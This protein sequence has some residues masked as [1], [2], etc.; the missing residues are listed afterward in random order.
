MIVVSILVLQIGVAPALAQPDFN[1]DIPKPPDPVT[2]VQS[3]PV[4]E[5]FYQD[6]ANRE[7]VRKFMA[8]DEAYRNNTLPPSESNYDPHRLANQ[9]VEIIQKGQIQATYSLNDYRL[10]PIEVGHSSLRI[11]YSVETRELLFEGVVGAKSDGTLGD[12][13]ARH[14]IP[15]IDL[16]SY[17][18]DLEMLTFID[19][20]GKLHA[21]DMGFAV[22]QL[23]KSPIPI[24]TN[25]WSPDVEFF[26]KYKPT[27]YRLQYHVRAITPYSPEQ[28]TEFSVIPQNSRGQPLF[29]AGDVYIT[30][31]DSS[32]QERVLG[33]FS[34]EIIHERFKHSATVLLA[35]ASL[36]KPKKEFLEFLALKL[37]GAEPAPELLEMNPLLRN[38]LSNLDLSQLQTLKHRAEANETAQQRSYDQYTLDE[39]AQDAQRLNEEF[40]KAKAAASDKATQHEVALRDIYQNFIEQEPRQNPFPPKETVMSKMLKRTDTESFRRIAA[41][42]AAGIG[43]SYL[44]FPFLYDLGL[45]GMEI[46]AMNWIYE[47]MYTDVMKGMYK[48]T[49]VKSIFSLLLMAPFIIYSCVFIQSMLKVLNKHVEHKDTWWAHKIKDVFKNWNGLTKWEFMGSIGLRQVFLLSYPPI[50]ALFKYIFQQRAFLT[51]VENGINPFKLVKPESPL[52]KLLEIQ[53]P[54]RMGLMSFT[55]PQGGSPSAREAL[56]KMNETIK[57]KHDR[58]IEIQS[59]VLNQKRRVQQFATNLATIIVAEKYKVD[60]ASLVMLMSEE[61]KIDQLVEI[62]R[63]PATFREWRVLTED[64]SKSLVSQNSAILLQQDFEE[65]KRPEYRSEFAEYARLATEKAQQL[66]ARSSLTNTLKFLYIGS[67]DVGAHIVNNLPFVNLGREKLSHLKSLYV[68]RFIAE[69]G[70]REFWTDYPVSVLLYGLV[71]GR[72]N[73]SDSANLSAGTTMHIGDTEERLPMLYFWTNPMHYYDMVYTL[74]A[75]LFTSFARMVLVF[76]EKQKSRPELSYLPKQ[77]ISLK[78]DERKQ[79]VLTAFWD[80]TRGVADLEK[81][82]LGGVFVQSYLN[83]VVT[84]QAGLV[85]TTILRLLIVP[86][87]PEVSFLQ[88]LYMAGAGFFLYMFWAQW[89]YGYIDD[90]VRQGNILFFKK[91]NELNRRHDEAKLKLQRGLSEQDRQFS[92]QLIREGYSELL[93]LYELQNKKILN[94]IVQSY[95]NEVQ[96]SRHA[97]Q[98]MNQSIIE[99]PK[100]LSAQEKNYYG[101]ILEATLALRESDADRFNRATAA[102]KQA[103]IENQ[104]LDPLEVEKLNARSIL[105]LSLSNPAVYTQENK[106]FFW[107]T[108]VSSLI[109]GTYLSI[110]LSIMIFNPEK[111]APASVAY[112]ALLSASFI[113]LVLILAGGRSWKYYK[114]IFRRVGAALSTKSRNISTYIAPNSPLTS[115]QKFFQ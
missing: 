91:H 115:C 71:G 32:G 86:V 39:L 108:Q 70:K 50:A 89:Q 66:R 42:T 88:N 64:I 101:L 25:L 34:R 17:S 52:G 47:N 100:D 114:S 10:E 68:N 92:Q 15:N 103:L 20:K 33:L 74:I 54:E 44:A 97:L 67:I 3:N 75:G 13:V 35:Q 27:S 18:K 59:A 107:V 55:M 22:E 56:E 98:M 94:L 112:T 78:S 31:Q 46:H 40:E 90:I 105:A 76:Q 62:H 14:I 16:V 28:L 29:Q 51:A 110:D 43:V 102:L 80:W 95:K 111:L 81:S 26:N 63:N 19:S 69:Q 106:L 57:R 61:I 72:A 37:T 109:W 58:K 23:F 73:K 41:I 83:R 9:R 12:V 77:Y 49:L 60:P 21:I 4:Y 84:M 48:F 79:G 104:N 38:Y 30:F 8:F 7:Y 2:A 82:D 99:L 87:G 85:L 93:S 113:P 11:R 36:V 53:K 96:N 5:E 6:T 65:L 1:R 45:S 24:V